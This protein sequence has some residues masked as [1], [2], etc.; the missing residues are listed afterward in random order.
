MK[1]QVS[2]IVVLLI[3][4][5]MLS[6]CMTQKPVEVVKRGQNIY[7]KNSVKNVGNARRIDEKLHS[8]QSYVTADASRYEDEE[9]LETNEL[10]PLKTTKTEEVAQ[11]H[12]GSAGY[13]SSKKTVKTTE[14]KYNEKELAPVSNKNAASREEFYE[15]QELPVEQNADL[16]GD[17]NAKGGGNKSPASASQSSSD[18]FLTSHPLANSSYNWPVSG[19]IVS[20]Y[21]KNGN[22]SNEG[23]N[24]LA[25]QGTPVKA[26]NSGK[27]TYIGQKVEGYGNLI[28][29][30]HDDNIMTAYAHLDGVNVVRGAKV[31]AGDVIG[32]VG[33]SGN[34]S[35]PQL[36][37]SVRNG[38][39][40]VN[41]EAAL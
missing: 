3:A 15:D 34:V 39:K 35:E 1:H 8:D 6:A 36:H 41:P 25:A 16:T 9:G 27:V 20:R 31:S 4:S 14:N 38:K 37:F 12:E 13:L 22:K 2:K 26:A 17:S 7:G 29:I 28:I 5:T 21:G 30:K 10:A 18:S 24:I 19:K 11:Q 32:T 23:I 33:K 40:T